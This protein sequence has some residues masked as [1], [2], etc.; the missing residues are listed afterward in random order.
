MKVLG[1]VVLTIH[2]LY[3]EKI[4]KI[5]KSEMEEET[6]E[7]QTQIKYASSVLRVPFRVQFLGLLQFRV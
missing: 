1:S 3:D 7:K 4:R 5:R 2:Y 6:E